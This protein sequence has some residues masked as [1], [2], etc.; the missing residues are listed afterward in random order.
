[1]CQQV[2]VFCF[3]R[4]TRRTGLE[5]D[6][7]IGGRSPDKLFHTIIICFAV[8][9]ANKIKKCGLFAQWQ[10][11]EQAGKHRTTLCSWSLQHF[12]F[13]P[14]SSAAS[15]TSHNHFT[16]AT[17]LAS[18]ISDSFVLRAFVVLCCP[19][20]VTVHTA[21]DVIS[22]HFIIISTLRL[23][24]TSYTAYIVGVRPYK[25][26]TSTGYRRTPSDLVADKTQSPRRW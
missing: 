21:A 17:V 20:R 7:R 11:A 16:F 1:M 5:I 3:D 9:Q 6:R 14:H 19:G 4:Q 8:P 22:G 12:H 25:C 2:H 26:L 13:W 24:N 10:T 18:H 15:S 23:L